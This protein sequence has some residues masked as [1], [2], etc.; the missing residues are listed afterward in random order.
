MRFRDI[1]FL[2]ALLLFLCST[3]C[4]SSKKSKTSTRKPPA[5]STQAPVKTKPNPP[6]PAPPSSTEGSIAVIASATH[7]AWLD[8]ERLM[9]VLEQAQRDDKA[10][11]VVFSASWCA[12]CKVMEEEVFSR[13][14]VFQHLNSKFLNFKADTDTEAGKAISAI[15]EVKGLPTVMFL[16]PNG[17]VLERYLGLANAS[18]IFEM[19]ESALEQMGK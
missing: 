9:P 8:S 1:I 16:S 7:V 4:N 5:R 13:P 6:A 19:S 11:F 14:D 12:P 2:S 10:V 17:V 3:A 15:H 18:K